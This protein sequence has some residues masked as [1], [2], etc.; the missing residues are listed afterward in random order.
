MLSADEID[1]YHRDVD[2]SGVATWKL[3]EWTWHFSTLQVIRYD[4][5]HVKTEAS[6]R[7]GFFYLIRWCGNSHVER[8]RPLSVVALRLHGKRDL[9][10][11]LLMA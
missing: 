7:R 3:W 1:R 6:P 11:P 4:R 9:T 8:T 10:C 5:L 2:A